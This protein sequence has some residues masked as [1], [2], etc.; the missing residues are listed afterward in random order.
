MMALDGRTKVN[1]CAIVSPLGKGGMD[2]VYL[3]LDLKLDTQ[4]ALKVLAAAVIRGYLI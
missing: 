2:E 1:H 3:A 4:V